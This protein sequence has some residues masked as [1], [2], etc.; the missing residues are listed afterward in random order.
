MPRY[1]VGE[2][3]IIFYDRLDR[4]AEGGTAGTVEPGGTAGWHLDL[5]FGR[6]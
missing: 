5:T 1:A 2:Q 3:P 6:R 4:A